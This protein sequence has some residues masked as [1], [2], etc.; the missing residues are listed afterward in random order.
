ML[1]R[2]R[3]H[4]HAPD[5]PPKG[6]AVIVVRFIVRVNMGTDDITKR[7]GGKRVIA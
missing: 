5:A 3:Q 1:C 6:F 7:Q 4:A 2:C